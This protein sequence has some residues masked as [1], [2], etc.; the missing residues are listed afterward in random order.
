MRYKISRSHVIIVLFVCLYAA[1]MFILQNNLASYRPYSSN[2]TGSTGTKAFY[3]LSNELGY[4]T[5]RLDDGLKPGING[6]K[7]LLVVIDQTFLPGK[8]AAGNEL[9]KWVGAGGNLLLFTGTATKLTESFGITINNQEFKGPAKIRASAFTKN[10]RKLNFMSGR[11]LSV[12]DSKYE[13]IASAAGGPV[14]LAFPFGRGRVVVVSDPSLITNSQI[15]KFDHIVLLLNVLRVIQPKTIWFDETGGAIGGG[16]EKEFH[17]NRTYTMAAI[18]FA[19]AVLLLFVFWGKR[20][21]RPL[22]LPAE[23]KGVSTQ[24]INTMANIFRQAK[25][26]DIALDNIFGAFWHNLTRSLGVPDSITPD[27]IIN[28]CRLR[29]NLDSPGLQAIIKSVEKFRRQGNSTEAEIFA[30]VHDMEK[31]RRENLKNARS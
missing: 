3:L 31:W 24:Y 10:V 19:L 4:K 15:Q 13:I 30:L 28:L 6:G 14:S 22:P 1:A 9:T 7:G 23:S 18:E 27:E 2:D 11:Y 12:K 8:S 26:R 21:G 17:L 5:Q 29:P 20:F 16:S 25:A